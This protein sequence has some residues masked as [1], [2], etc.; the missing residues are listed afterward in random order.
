MK[1]LLILVRA[2]RLVAPV[3]VALLGAAVLHGVVD[4]AVWEA[5]PLLDW[6][7]AFVLGMAFLLGVFFRLV[8]VPAMCLMLTAAV[9]RGNWLLRTQMEPW[10]A[11]F[12][13]IAS[14]FLALFTTVVNLQGERDPLRLPGALRL[15]GSFG[16]AALFFWMTGSEGLVR[17]VASLPGALGSS[18]A[19]S[20]WS[21]PPVGTGFFISSVICLFLS[22]QKHSAAIVLQAVLPAFIALTACGD[23]S[24][25][26]GIYGTWTCYMT[27]AAC[28]LLWGVL[29]S[30]WRNAYMDELTGL[31][32]RRPFLQ[33]LGSAGSEYCVAV[34]DA[35]HFKQVN[36]TYGHDVGDQVLRYIAA[37]VASVRGGRAYR[38]GGEEF[39]I[40]F[41]RGNMDAH[42]EA[43]EE[44]RACIGRKR[45]I[46]RG[47]DRPRRKPKEGGKP[48]KGGT[49]CIQITVSIGAA[50]SHG[51]G[52]PDEVFRAADQALYRAKQAGRNRV[53]T[54]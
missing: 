11:G 34:V 17:N 10:G 44:V 1:D 3:G 46:L 47:G 22:P 28:V 39:V 2:G 12:I 9:L 13:W 38:Y 53:A 29:D 8:R 14:V 54:D 43:L 42:L 49:R 25:G 50:D 6:I 33:H 7:P 26:T 51:G 5:H 31:P 24:A 16:V 45:F 27:A 52:D 32:G 21:I 41:G 35:D 18:P 48:T 19:W 40:I 15:G 36:D 4:T 37:E 23:L 20:F 30:A